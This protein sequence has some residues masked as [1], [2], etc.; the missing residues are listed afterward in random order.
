MSLIRCLKVD[1]L[2]GPVWIVSALLL[3]GS[4]SMSGL[5]LAEPLIAD[6]VCDAQK[7]KARKAA[8]PRVE[9]E[10]PSEFDKQ[11]PSLAACD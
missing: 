6:S 4:V 7:L 2:A 11:F 8:D 1:W 10:I 5:A 9:I 3:T